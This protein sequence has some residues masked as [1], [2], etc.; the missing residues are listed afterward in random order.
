MKTDNP[1]QRKA[2]R[3]VCLL[4]A[5][6]HEGSNLGVC[7]LATGAINAILSAS[8]NASISIIDYDHEPSVHRVPCGDREVEIPLI[9]IRFSK[10]LYL[11][12]NITTLIFLAVAMKVIRL[13]C[14]RRGILKRSLPLE[15]LT[16]ADMIGSLAGG[17]SFSDLYGLAR[18]FYVALPQILVVLLGKK[19]VLLPQTFG[20]FRSFISTTIAVWIIS[21]ADK[22]LCREGSGVEQLRRLL[23]GRFKPESIRF[24]YDVGLL[25]EPQQAKNAEVPDILAMP[26][27]DKIIVGLNVSGLLYFNGS[28]NAER[29][30]AR[31]NYQ[32][33]MQA[34]AQHLLDRGD[35]VLIVVPH[36]VGTGVDCDD[37]ACRAIYE[38]FSSYGNCGI[39]QG[40]F[41]VGEI[42]SLIGK[43]DVFVGSRMHACIG[44][45]SQNVPTVGIAYS[46]KFVGVMKTLQMDAYVADLRTVEV[47]EINS[48]IDRVLAGRKEIQ[49]ELSSKMSLAK[50]EIVAEFENIMNPP[51]GC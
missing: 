46:D 11:V 18:L 30:G 23:K 13:G 27:K 48:L 37:G 20:P 47:D 8:P 22:V 29:F 17:D 31:S 15:H 34:V 4:G 3:K 44:A 1:D 6:L 5:N 40:R 16:S 50:A 49:R 10:K 12:N 32:I 43:C 33:L 7:A 28:K 9:N 14:L 35:I 42:K 38:S 36:G 39:I 21:R 24:C 51:R 41:T 19:L 2:E 26:T 25:V 45:I